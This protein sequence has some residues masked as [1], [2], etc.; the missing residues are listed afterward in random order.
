[1]TFPAHVLAELSVG[2]PF[3]QMVVAFAT[4]CALAIMNAL[5]VS[6]LLGGSPWFGT[7]QKAATYILITGAISPAIAALGGAF[8]PVS[9]GEPLSG[10]WVY[11]SAW[12]AGNALAAMTFGP[13]LLGWA[14]ADWRPLRVGWRQAEAALFATTLLAISLVSFAMSVR[15]SPSPFVPA[16]LYV[17]LP[18]I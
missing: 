17:P 16:L 3:G 2:M 4:N 15:I 1:M 10:Y 6:R 11:W 12:F 5:A 14:E 13:L 18:V 9:G 7:L 8:V